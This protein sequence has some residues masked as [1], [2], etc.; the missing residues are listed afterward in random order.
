[1]C[2][3][4]LSDAEKEASDKARLPRLCEKHLEEIKLK[5]PQCLKVFKKMRFS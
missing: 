3:K 4:E 2:R 5:L 1:M